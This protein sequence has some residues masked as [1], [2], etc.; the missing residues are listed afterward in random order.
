MGER[1]ANQTEKILKDDDFIVSK[2]DL[3]GRITYGNR[4]FAAY[5][6]LGEPQYLGNRTT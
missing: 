4:T 6:G 5:A 2:P 1:P 3:R